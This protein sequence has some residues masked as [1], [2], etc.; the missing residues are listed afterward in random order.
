MFDSIM[1]KYGSDKKFKESIESDPIDSPP[2]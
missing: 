2:H 1:V